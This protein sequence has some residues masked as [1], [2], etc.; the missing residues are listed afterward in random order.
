[1]RVGRSSTSFASLESRSLRGRSRY[2]LSAKRRSGRRLD[3]RTF[4]IAAEKSPLC[5][6]KASIPHEVPATS[7]GASTSQNIARFV[8]A[9]SNSRCGLTGSVH[10]R[11]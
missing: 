1:M 4:Q 8:Y 6:R 3:K 5:R 2:P 11:R 7:T 10:S 9:K